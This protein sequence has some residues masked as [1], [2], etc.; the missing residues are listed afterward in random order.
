MLYIKHV[1]SNIKKG[2]DV[3]LGER[4]LIY[5]PNGS[6]KSSVVQAIELATSGSVN[7]TEGRNS[8]K[9]KGAIARLFPQDEEPYVKL[10]LSD[11]Q[12][13]NW[14][15]NQDNSGIATLQIKVI[16]E[17]LASDA[18]VIR[19]WLSERILGN[20]TEESIINSLVT[21]RQEEIRKLIKR[22]KPEL[23]YVIVAT[24]AKK[25]ATTLKREATM[26]EKTLD[27][28]IEG[29]PLPANAAKV[30]QIEKRITETEAK[31]A[32]LNTGVC[33]SPDVQ[34]QHMATLAVLNAKEDEH[35][36]ALQTA[37]TKMMADKQAFPTL[38]SALARIEQIDMTRVNKLV[39]LKELIEY[40]SETFGTT[41]CFVCGTPGQ[42]APEGITHQYKE[43][44]DILDRQGE[45]VQL[46][47]RIR[48]LKEIQRLVAESKSKLNE[49][50]VV[51]A[52]ALI[53][54]LTSDKEWIFQNERNKKSYDAVKGT[55]AE[56]ALNRDKAHILVQAGDELMEIGKQLMEEGSASFLDE[57]QEYLPSSFELGMDIDAGRIGFMRDG[58]LHTSLSGAEWSQMLIALSL[59]DIQY[60]KKK[61]QGHHRTTESL[62]VT[63]ADDRAWDAETLALLMNTLQEREGQVILMS[64]VYPEGLE[65]DDAGW[66]IVS[67]L[68][69]N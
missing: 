65:D 48:E 2:V 57:V 45:M 4:S 28:L 30:A 25:A 43:V 21:S 39:K 9:L 36:A 26:K 61:M 68:P 16:K 11:G 8:V 10:T 12:E 7:D 34:K 69:L 29:I 56:I 17:I 13:I 59:Y 49:L 6:G 55:K 24:A 44:C 53:D 51:D 19:S 60:A 18:K 67:T 38:D 66:S 37:L 52:Q 58:V 35:I 47:Q 54:Q 46:S 63:I 22:E 41:D 50:K 31:I 20:V 1:T 62:F 23:D 64:T 27:S 42:V 3:S 32:E 5:G 40:Y 14:S 33:V 15:L